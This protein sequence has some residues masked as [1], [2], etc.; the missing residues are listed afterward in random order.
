MSDPDTTTHPNTLK[1]PHSEPSSPSGGTQA[2]DDEQD[3]H[4]RR[5]PRIESPATEDVVDHSPSVVLQEEGKIFDPAHTDTFGFGHV[6]WAN[7][8][9]EQIQFV[10]QHWRTELLA[11]YVFDEGAVAHEEPPKLVSNLGLGNVKGTGVAR[12]YFRS[13][14]EV[15]DVVR[16]FR[17]DY[18]NIESYY[19]L[20]TH[21]MPFE[22]FF[23]SA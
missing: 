12:R 23:A 3:Q 7:L 1:R 6:P 2:L 5:R 8:T 11:D 10:R 13:Y 17:D 4:S 18:K 16:I 9:P 20:C 19:N 21:C 22:L 14:P 15:A